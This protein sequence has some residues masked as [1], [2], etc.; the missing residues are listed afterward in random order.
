MIHRVKTIGTASE[1]KSQRVTTSD[2][3]TGSE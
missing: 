3:T 2:T 1:S